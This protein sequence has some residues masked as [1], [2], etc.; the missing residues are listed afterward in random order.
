MHDDLSNRKIYLVIGI[1]LL[2]A[3]GI[4]LFFYVKGRNV[5][6]DLKMVS[7]TEYISNEQ[8]QVI[9][10]L[11]DSTGTS[12]T[13]A[14]CIVSLLYPDKSFFFVDR[15]MSPTTV[16]GNYYVS[17]I[18]PETEGIYEESIRCTIIRN[19]T[20][21]ILQVS[22]SF[23]VS[24]GLNL[25]VE[26]S[27]SQREQYVALVQR[28]NDLDNNLTARINSVDA[29]VYGV[30]NYIDNNVMNEF[31][32][33]NTQFGAVNSKINDINVSISDSMN[34]I[35]GRLNTTML[36]NFTDLYQKFKSSYNAMANVFDINYP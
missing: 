33:V 11:Q 36:T 1:I 17:F 23:H 30:Q 13:D 8:G 10:R 19:G 22:S 15:E 20:P 28:L 3:I 18:T 14:N 25:I 31:N 9:V 6:S 4:F 26:V 29:R 24:T 27:R 5:T 32:N 34:G 2:L 12:I 16:P 7:G 21:R 35:E